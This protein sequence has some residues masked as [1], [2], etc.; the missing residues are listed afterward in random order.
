M[1]IFYVLFWYFTDFYISYLKISFEITILVQDFYLLLYAY[2]ILKVV[3]SLR[4][5]FTPL[6]LKL[7]SGRCLFLY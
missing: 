3:M 7:Y 6:L 4:C 5:S 2:N 1:F